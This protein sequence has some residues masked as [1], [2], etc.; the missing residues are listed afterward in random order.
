MELE[1]LARLGIEDETAQIIIECF[2]KK[3]AEVSASAESKRIGDKYSLAVH[4]ALKEAGAVNIRAAM[5]VL[6]H[7]FNGDDFDAEPAGLSDAVESLKSEA[8][9]LFSDKDK[10][11]KIY[12][13]VGITPASAVD[14]D[15]DAGEL[16]YS[17]YMRLYRD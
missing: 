5:A 8:P 15:T 16:S 1:F 2:E 11:E 9:Y 3:L 13:F 7:E 14:A 10:S 6:E 4:H 17:E 12:T